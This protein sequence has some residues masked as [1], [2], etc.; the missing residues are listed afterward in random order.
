VNKPC[1]LDGD[2][3]FMNEGSRCEELRMR[4]DAGDWRDV[5]GYCKEF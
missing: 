3:L 5:G 1:A 2:W 4:P